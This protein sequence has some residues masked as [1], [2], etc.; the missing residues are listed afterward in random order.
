MR[1]VEEK[2]RGPVAALNGMVTI[3]GELNMDHLKLHLISESGKKMEKERNNRIRSSQEEMKEV[4]WFFMYI[5]EKT[6]GENYKEAYELWRE[7]NPLTRRKIGAKLLL[8][9]LN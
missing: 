2:S 7:R 5:K 4:M 1:Q 3:R 6:L 9:Q 8:N